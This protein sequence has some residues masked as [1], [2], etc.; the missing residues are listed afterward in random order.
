MTGCGE[1][2]LST[3]YYRIASI[4]KTITAIAMM[5]LIEQHKLHLNDR[6]FCRKGKGKT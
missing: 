6:I 4:S 1:R 2:C 5:Q 3:S